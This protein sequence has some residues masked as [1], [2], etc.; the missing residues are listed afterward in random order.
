MTNAELNLAIAKLV[1]PNHNKSGTINQ[2]K[3]TSTVVINYGYPSPDCV[4]YTE[5][6]DSLMPLVVEHKI[7]LVCNEG[8]N[9]DGSDMWEACHA[10]Q[11]EFAITSGND[12][13]RA[14]AECLLKVLQEKDERTYGICPLE[15]NPRLVE[16][17]DE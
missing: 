1:Y 15:S 12:P 3:G 2:I 10:P 4:N 17:S 14:L 8:W 16:K 7:E 9:K 6:W 13:Q 5:C 11:G